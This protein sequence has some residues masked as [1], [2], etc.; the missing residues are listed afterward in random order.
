[1][2][3]DSLLRIQEH[4]MSTSQLSQVSILP[5][6]IQS[7]RSERLNDGFEPTIGLKSE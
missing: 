1:V 5:E 4:P 6:L 3:F 2:E 7:S